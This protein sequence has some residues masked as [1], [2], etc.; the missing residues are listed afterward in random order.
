[1]DIIKIILALLF[2]AAFWLA[3]LVVCIAVF[4][5]I[6]GVIIAAIIYCVFY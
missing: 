3:P 1:M 6:G 4:G 2:L 5:P